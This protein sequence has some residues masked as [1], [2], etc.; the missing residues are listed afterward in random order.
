MPD[1]NTE[2]RGLIDPRYVTWEAW[3]RRLDEVDDRFKSLRDEET[4]RETRVNEQL[5]R[6]GSEIV[7][8]RIASARQAVYIS[9][10]QVGITAAATGWITYLVVHH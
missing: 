7:R 10:V 1:G 6:Q 2:G 4:L 3:N 5:G 8:L 9:L